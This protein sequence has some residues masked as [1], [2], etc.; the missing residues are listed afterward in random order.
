MNSRKHEIVKKIKQISGRYSTQIVFGDWI[1]CLALSISNACTL[2][3]QL[4]QKREEEYKSIIAKYNEEEQ[5]TFVEMAGLLVLAYEEEM[6]DVLGEIYMESI[7]GNKNTG[8]FFTPY[9]VS[10]ACAKLSI[11]YHGEPIKLNEPTCGSGGMVV[12]AAQ[13]LKTQG[14]NY[15]SALDVV[16]QDLDWTAV[17]MCYVQLSLLG[18]KAIVVQGNTLT[19]P[20]I[21]RYPAS[22]TFYTPAKKMSLFIGG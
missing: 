16:C 10:L 3:N 11:A 6:G 9:H 14:V 1:R 21:E 4:W 19:D 20:Y 2:R 15:Q 22:R 8:Q 17:F 12:A 5:L 7:G 18:V 13:A